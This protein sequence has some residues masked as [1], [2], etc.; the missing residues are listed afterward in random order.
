MSSSRAAR[1]CS[2]RSM[3]ATCRRCCSTVQA[4]VAGAPNEP[5]E[6]LRAGLSAF[7]TATLADERAARI[8][9]VEMVGVSPALEHNAVGAA[10]LRR[11]DRHAG[12]RVRRPAAADHR[13]SA[14]DRGRARGRHRRAD[15][16]L[17]VQRAAAAAEQHRADAAGDLHAL[18]RLR[19]SRPA[20][21][22]SPRRAARTARSRRSRR[23]PARRRRGRTPAGPQRGALVEIACWASRWTTR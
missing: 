19:R 5:T 14:D 21:R 17:A 12:R 16:R 2:A 22:R 10:R 23:G 15:H 18:S 4:A 11:A 13:R 6:R 9:Y 3:T 7:V 1:R 20:G 8:N